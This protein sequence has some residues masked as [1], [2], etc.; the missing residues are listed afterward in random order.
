MVAGRTGLSTS[1]GG[2]HGGPSVPEELNFQHKS[3]RARLPLSA[4]LNK[5]FLIKQLF[6]VSR[7]GS[8]NIQQIQNT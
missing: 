4:K 5:L 1:P 2:R 3:M 6:K 8:K 7:I